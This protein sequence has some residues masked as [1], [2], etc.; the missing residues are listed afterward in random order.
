M[1]FDSLCLLL[2]RGANGPTDI[3]QDDPGP[4]D[5]LYTVCVV[6]VCSVDSAVKTAHTASSLDMGNVC[7]LGFTL[8][9]FFSH[10]TDVDFTGG[11]I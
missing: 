7:F 11:R 2:G 5:T 10:I 1:R 3:S 4:V 6:S 9:C 8:E